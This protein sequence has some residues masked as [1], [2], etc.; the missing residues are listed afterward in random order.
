MTAASLVPLLPMVMV[1]ASVVAVLLGIAVRRSHIATLTLTLAGLACAC[2][3]LPVAS[4][5]PLSLRSVAPL[6]IMDGYA[7]FLAGL[8]IMTAFLTAVL[9]FD[10][11]RRHSKRPEEYYALLLVAALGS[12]VL[13]AS[14]QFVSFFLGIEMMSVPLYALIAYLRSKDEHLE[15]GIKYLI[16]SAVSTSFLLFGMALVYA[17]F[18]V[19]EF[20][21]I[22]DMLASFPFD[23]VALTGTAMLITGVGFKLAVV[24]FHMWT[25]DVYEG[26]PAPVAAFI[27][28][29]S[30]GAVFALL[31]RYF[32]DVNISE[33]GP[34]FLIFSII[35]VISMFTGNILALFQDNVKRMLAY[36][37]IAHF[38]YLLVAFLSV[39]ALRVVAVMFYLVQYFITTLGAFGVVTI[40]SRAGCDADMLEDY[41]GL[42][43]RRPWLAVVFSLSLLSLAGLP[44][45]AGFIG[46]FLIV[47]AGL[48]S[49]APLL[50]VA[51]VIN[52][53][54]GLFYYLRAMT[55]MFTAQPGTDNGTTG[56]RLSIASCLVICVLAMLVAWWGVFPSSLVDLILSM[57]EGA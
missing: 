19:M 51:L 30:K 6:L 35:A 43:Y 50:V 16:L 28:T 29:V 54:I 31:L 17:R 5:A 2:L 38:G 56:L 25:P 22:T 8:I 20:S 13:A 44:L 11:L 4:V 45:T 52:S 42:F 48:G 21:R 23:A 46:K 9:S 1:A 53:V 55:P 18:G 15:A 34:L 12:L 7:Y 27:A 33:Q 32:S 37:S 3:S 14:T 24:P 40:M 10:Y 49:A 57:T 36:S 41:Y 26:A 47:T 39:G